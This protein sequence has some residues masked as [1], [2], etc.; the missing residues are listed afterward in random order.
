[1][2]VKTFYDHIKSSIFVVCTIIISFERVWYTV[3]NE[4]INYT[5]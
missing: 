3:I 1:M 2:N 4:A 5:I